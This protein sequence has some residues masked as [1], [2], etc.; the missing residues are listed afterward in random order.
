MSFKI[1][2]NIPIPHKAAGRPPN[3]KIHSVLE[4]MEI[5]DSFALE[6][7]ATTTSGT[8]YSK[9]LNALKTAGIRNYNYKF[10]QRLSDDKKK[11]RIWR[12]E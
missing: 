2:K 3:E 1:E 12:I 4:N 5:G 11:I 10:V 8:A 9:F 6:T 7:D